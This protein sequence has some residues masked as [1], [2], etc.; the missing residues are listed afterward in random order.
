MTVS[1]YH[2]PRC[3]KS[4]AA[5]K[6]LEDEKIEFD[7]V[8]YLDGGLTAEKLTEILAALD[9]QAKDVMRKGEAIFK[10]LGLKDAADEAKLIDAIIANPILLE[11]PI[12]LNGNK[13][14]IGRP[15]ENIM[16]L[17]D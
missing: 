15:L 3:S 4:R 10:Q 14:A 9:M 11:R 16:A 13:A 12:V 6:Y 17:F 2:N 1:I 7:I 5:L 8:T